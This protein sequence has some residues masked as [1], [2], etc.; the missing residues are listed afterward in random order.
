[1][2]NGKHIRHEDRFYIIYVLGED[3]SS[4]LACFTGLCL[5][6]AFQGFFLFENFF[7]KSLAFMQAWQTYPLNYG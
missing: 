5:K 4:R 7:D 1:M 6:H 3:M 2:S